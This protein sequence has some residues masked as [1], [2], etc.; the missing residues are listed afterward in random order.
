MLIS[1]KYAVFRK[2]S[3]YIS[4][5]KASSNGVREAYEISRLNRVHKYLTN[6]TEK[7]VPTG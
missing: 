3:A 7:S 4:C 2:E 5:E 1:L 6:H